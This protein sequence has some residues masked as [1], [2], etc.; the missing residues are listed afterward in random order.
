[1]LGAPPPPPPA[2]VAGLR[3]LLADLP[4]GAGGSGC[5]AA[6]RERAEDW[7]EQATRWGA[8]SVASMVRLGLQPS[9]VQSL[10]VGE[11]A[12]AEVR[13]R[14]EEVDTTLAPPVTPPARGWDEL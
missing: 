12:A 13:R 11:P 4:D 9:F 1:M 5:D 10:A 8:S 6:C 14:L 7:F 3:S 2:L